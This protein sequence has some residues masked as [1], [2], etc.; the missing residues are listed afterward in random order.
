MTSPGKHGETIPITQAATS[1]AQ[2]FHRAFGHYACITACT[3][4]PRGDSPGQSCHEGS[5]SMGCCAR[6]SC[7]PISTVQRAHVRK[8]R[9]PSQ[10]RTKLFVATSNLQ[11]SVAVMARTEAQ[12]DEEQHQDG[13]TRCAAAKWST[14]CAL[15]VRVTLPPTNV[16]FWDTLLYISTKT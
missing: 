11:E 10:S 15:R 16:G 5:I 12:G 8:S 4:V 14:H 13:C 1:A 9:K 3:S 7:H 6:R 2:P